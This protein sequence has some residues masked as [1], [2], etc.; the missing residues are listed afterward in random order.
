MTAT[1]AATPSGTGP[2]SSYR[3]LLRWRL[4][5]IG[6]TVLPMVVVVQ[7]LLAAGL[8]VGFGFLIP[9]V[10][11]AAASYL[12][13][14]TPTALL[15]I[16]GLVLL[17]GGVS[18]AR[19]DGTLHYLRTLPLPRSVPLLVEL[20]VWSTVASPASSLP[21]WSPTSASASTSRSTGRC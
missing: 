12:A 19:A 15:M 5:Q 11:V 21:W 13:T 20:T 9:E 4:A 8:I 17:P 10:D 2:A 7:S 16:V 1:I 3:T 6:G 14:G 18:D